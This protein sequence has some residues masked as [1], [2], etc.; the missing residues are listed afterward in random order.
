VTGRSLVIDTDTASD[1][2]VAIVLAA[3]DPEVAIRMVTVVAGNVPLDLAVRNA[4]VTL[5]LVDH[6]SVPVHAGA[7]Q[8]LRRP[9]ET[10]QSVHGEDGMGGADLPT[11]SRRP[12]TEVAVEAL[13]RVAADEPGQHG[14]V[15][16]GPLTNIAMALNENP[17][18]LTRFTHTYL[19]AGSPDGVGNMNALGEYNVWADPEAA[20]IVF[21]ADGAKTMIGWN[22]SR[23][24]AVM[25]P[26]ET[27]RLRSCGRLGE[28]AV[29]INA[30]VDRFCRGRGL[31]GMDL[32]DPVAMAVA[33][34]ES[35]VTEATEERLIVGLDE[36]TRGAALPD[37]RFLADLPN[38]RVVWQVD[39]AAF[40][41]RLYAAC[42]D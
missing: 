19:M 26:Q 42:S 20:S 21:D 10:A 6:C 16:L 38:L 30:E 35:I 31:V 28:F 13:L 29:D 7:D 34:D 1:D 5:D 15:T 24:Y 41:D 8:P 11:P 17:D 4:I 36:P 27:A 2:A 23:T 25:A 39:E 9:L 3:R 22:I 37:R 40:K 18:L 32:P 12:S 33:L 14:L